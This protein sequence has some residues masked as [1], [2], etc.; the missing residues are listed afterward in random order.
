M[1]R[2][3][4]AEQQPV[5]AWPLVLLALPAGVAI[6][7][8]WVGIGRLTGFGVVQPFPGVP[9]LDGLQLDTAITL[10]I[11]MEAYAAYAL[12][13]W[14]TGRAPAAARQ[15][16]RRSAVGALALGALGQVAYHL[17]IAAGVVKA[18]WWITTLV[19]CLPVA[20]LGMGAALHHLMTATPAAAPAP[21]P[22][23][24]SPVPGEAKTAVPGDGGT[25]PGLPG[26]GAPPPAATGRKRPGK[27]S[28]P[29]AAGPT[30]DEV[31]LAYLDTPGHSAKGLARHLRAEGHPIG[32]GPAADLYRSLNGSPAPVLEAVR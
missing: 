21:S 25:P 6:W 19:S 28:R 7:S 10:P 32:N 17:M 13:V 24:T 27:A 23:A 3:P 18:P 8:G 31:A 26:N 30:R 11:G 2:A 14:L 12:R 1:S 20:V 22:V 16:A 15:F 29:A 5:K 9:V 4:G